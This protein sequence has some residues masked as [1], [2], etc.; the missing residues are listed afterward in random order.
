MEPQAPIALT[1]PAAGAHPGGAI[2]VRGSAQVWEGRVNVRLVDASGAVLAS[3]SVTAS[4][5]APERGAFALTLQAPASL[6]G[7]AAI[8]AYASSPRDGSPMGLTRVEL[9]IE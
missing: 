4:A 7:E 3:E 1:A 2:A 5:S 6:R 9:L 8:E